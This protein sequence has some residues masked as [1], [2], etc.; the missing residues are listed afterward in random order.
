MLV[1][2]R[3]SSLQLTHSPGTPVFSFA[4]CFLFF[5]H[6]WRAILNP[7]LMAGLPRTQSFSVDK[8]NS[9]LEQ[10]LIWSTLRLLVNPPK[11]RFYQFPGLNHLAR[12]ALK[13]LLNHKW[14]F[15]GTNIV[16]GVIYSKRLGGL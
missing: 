14:D 3:R 16:L 1:S 8:C 9:I 11:C 12:S 6:E 2:S 5:V 7:L 10:G 4:W 15:R 13:G